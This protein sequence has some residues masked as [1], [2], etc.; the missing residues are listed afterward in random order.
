MNVKIDVVIVDDWFCEKYT[1]RGL[2]KQHLCQKNVVLLA[3]LKLA[4]V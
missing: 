1:F 4:H 2:K 3:R